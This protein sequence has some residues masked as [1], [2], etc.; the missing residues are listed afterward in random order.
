MQK[1][2][3]GLLVTN[4]ASTFSGTTPS[5]VREGDSFRRRW[6][7]VELGIGI[8]NGEYCNDERCQRC[9]RNLGAR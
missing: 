6:V 5:L 1:R 9:G 2:R 3:C 4:D 7:G 8:G